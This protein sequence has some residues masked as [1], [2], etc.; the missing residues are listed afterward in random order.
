MNSDIKILNVKVSRVNLKETMC[1]FEEWIQKKLKKRICVLPVNC[2]LWAHKNLELASI[3]NSADLCLADGV[4]LL[5]AS[6]WLGSPIAGR[7][8]GLDLLP[9]FAELA[10][11]RNYSFFFMGAKE[12]VAVQLADTLLAKYPNLRIVGTY[13]P[14]F[15]KSFSE[16]ENKKIIDLVNSAKP[17]VLWV[18]LTAPKQDIWIYQNYEKLDVPITLGVGGAFDVTAGI[19][20]R[21]PIWMQHAGLEW[22]Y[23][24]LNEPF[25]LFRRYFIEAPLFIPLIVGQV[26]KEKMFSQSYMQ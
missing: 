22:F 15:S 26:I 19:V 18:S 3:Y 25:R 4:P 10:S 5:W 1:L 21:A 13:S 6:K 20:P 23:R 7:V 9:A 12:G 2:I 24:F 14:P 8:T 11:I 16:E 17:D